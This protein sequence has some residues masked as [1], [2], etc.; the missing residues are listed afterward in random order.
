VLEGCFRGRLQ[1]RICWFSDRL[2]SMSKNQTVTTLCGAALALSL[3]LPEFLAHGQASQ[4]PAYSRMESD[5]EAAMAAQD[6]GDL[7]RAEAILAALH[8]AHPGN[9]AIDE[10][11]GLA[12]VSR[13]ALDEALPLLKAASK[14]QPSSDAAHANLG[15]A[16]YR[17]HHNAESIMEFERAVKINPANLSAQQSLGSV[18]MEEHRP[19]DAARVTAAA[20]ALKPEDA[21]LQL[22]HATALLAAGSIDEARR[23][24]SRFPH[25]GQSARA[26][27]LL[28]EIDEMAKDFTGAGRRFALA[29]DLEPSEENA[30]ALGVELLRH[31][32]FDAAARE[33]E[34]AIVKFPASRRMRLG[35][36]AA[37]FGDTKYPQAIPVFAD[38]LDAEPDNAQYAALLGITCA[39]IKREA[40]P[41]CSSLIRYA[42]THPH[43]ASAS[44]DAAASLLGE[45]DPGKR[46]WRRR[47]PAT[48]NY[49]KRSSRWAHFCK[50]TVSG[51]RV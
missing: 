34:A 42:Q 23:L 38:L 26:Q 20:L 5:F 27:V 41:R 51:G 36:G 45:E 13:N 43:D 18:L 46:Y 6:R 40:R 25:A 14:E 16:L 33:F 21:D 35:L 3:L 31:W 24:L 39:T 47:W 10:S 50:T 44:V 9:F 29:V 22:D 4:P 15:A 17:L 28:G 1:D 19:A 7:A 37:L 11:L 12:L 48:P 49:P 32:N 8:K 30:W 2:E